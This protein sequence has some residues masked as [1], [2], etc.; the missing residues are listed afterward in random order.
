[1]ILTICTEDKTCHYNKEGDSDI[2]ETADMTDA[3]V[4]TVKVLIHEVKDYISV[5][6]I[7]A[8]GTLIIFLSLSTL[9]NNN[10]FYFF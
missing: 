7:S 8:E 6:N 3:S 9:F 4:I 5:I 2:K 1:M 10:T